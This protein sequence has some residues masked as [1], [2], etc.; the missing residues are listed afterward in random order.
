METIALRIRQCNAEPAYWLFLSLSL[1]NQV[2]LVKRPN[3][4]FDNI[5]SS[6]INPR[7]GRATVPAERA[8][9][10]RRGFVLR[11]RGLG[12]EGEF[13]GDDGVEVIDEASACFAALCALACVRLDGQLALA[14]RNKTCRLT[15][16]F[17]SW[18][19]ANSIRYRIPP[20]RHP[21]V[22]VFGFGKDILVSLG[23]ETLVRLYNVSM[24]LR[25]CKMM[26]LSK[27]SEIIAIG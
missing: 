7:N 10:A 19:G 22:I 4:K 15:P 24:D 26:S 3:R 25:V 17:Q 6:P 13:G 9:E 1:P 14:T 5:R 23:D 27:P 2:L 8:I 20:Q 18:S 16:R 21:P 11:V 12:E